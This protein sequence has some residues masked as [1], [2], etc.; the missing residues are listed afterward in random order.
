MMV[1]PP[2]RFSVTL[3]FMW[4]ELADRYVPDAKCTTPPPV[5][6]L[7]RV[8]HLLMA[9]VS[10][11]DPSPFAPHWLDFTSNVVAADAG[12]AVA[13]PPATSATPAA[14]NPATRAARDAATFLSALPNTRTL[15][16]RAHRAAGRAARV[17]GTCLIDRRNPFQGTRRRRR[18]RPG[19]AGPRR[20]GCRTAWTAR[21][22]RPTSTK[23][24]ASMHLAVA[25][26]A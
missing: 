25:V 19:R 23:P 16:L 15:S 3:L 24:V 17:P 2:S 22:D 18:D 4:M 1:A 5:A 7:A 13:M 26:P 11:A 10:L 8:M 20:R 21:R 14:A 9:A 6:P 12:T